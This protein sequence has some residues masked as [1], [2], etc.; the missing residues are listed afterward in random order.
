M[1]DLRWLQNLNRLGGMF[2]GQEQ[3]QQQPTFEG[4]YNPMGQG[5]PQV[6]PGQ[7]Q[8]FNPNAEKD[9]FNNV[10]GDALSAHLK[11]YPERGPVSN[12]RKLGAA[13]AGMG[14]NDPINTTRDYINFHHDNKL[15]DWAVKGSAVQ[16]AANTERLT[17]QS[18]MQQLINERRMEETER[19]NRE[20][21]A[22]NREKLEVTQQRADTSQH[23]AD[24]YR[25]ISRGGQM[26]TDEAGNTFVAFKDG[27]SVPVNINQFSTKELEELR[28]KNRLGQIA[29]TGS[30][31][32]KTADVRGDNTIEAIRARGDES[33]EQIRERGNQTRQTATTRQVATGVAFRNET[34]QQKAARL[35]NV[36][37]E[38]ISRKP[39]LAPYIQFDE[40]GRFLRTQLPEGSSGFL[41]YGV[42]PG[43]DKKILEDINN[44]LFGP[45]GDKYSPPGPG[46]AVTRPAN[47]PANYLRV[48]GPNGQTG[49]MSPEELRTSPGWKAK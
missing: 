1:I 26:I 32:R 6:V 39:E 8:G 47:V 35:T 2:G 15:K 17:N 16:Q 48:I 28:N 38:I 9:P 49:W 22:L 11:A 31:A 41:G 27:S 23:R 44:T 4:S 30:E 25:A 40:Q 5:V 43:G 21:E 36:A 19:K 45:A 46:G 18:M 14:S 42:K 20:I 34:P 10:A 33:V 13:I 29:A 24:T 37:R 12:W 7:T 3:T